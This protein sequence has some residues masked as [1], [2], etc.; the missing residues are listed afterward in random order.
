MSWIGEMWR[1]GGM[2][3]RGERFDR[4]LDEELRL[5]R[6]M[7]ERELSE[8]GVAA[9]EAKHAANRAFGNFTSLRERTREAW[10]WRWLENFVEDCWYGA[11]GLRK[12]PGY[13][14]TTV[15]TLILGI[16][17][18]TAIFSVVNTVLLRPLPYIDP[19]RLVQIEE[20][21]DG[22]TNFSYATY[23]D[24]V[25]A[26]PKSLEEIASYRPW[27]F[28]ISGGAE[29]EQT[30]GAMASMDLFAAL[31]VRPELGRVFTSD[32][33]HE[34]AD[35]VAV[36]SYGL[37]QRQFG[38]STDAIGKTI[39]VS[40]IPTVIVGVMPAGF[41]F[42]RGARIWTPLVA[43]GELQNN[44]RAH[45]FHV[46]GRTPKYVTPAQVE[47]EL[48]GFARGVEEQ[49]R[50]VDPGL[51]ITAGNLRERITA[52]VRPGLLVLLGAVGLV[53]L[54]ACANVANLMLMR[55]TMRAREF[56]VRA[57]LGAGRSRLLRQCFAESTVLGALGAGGGVL[58]AIWCTK[59]IAASGPGDVPRLNEVRA[60]VPTMLFAA[61]LALLTAFVFGAVPAAEA[62]WSDP[63]D[64]LKE[65]A[66]GTASAKGRKLRGVLVVAEIALAL[67]LLAGAGLLMNS[68]VRLSRVSP[69]FDEGNLL[70]ANVFLSPMKFSDEQIAPF[71]EAVLERVRAL[72]GVKSAG[73]VNTLPVQGGAATDFAVEGRPTPRPEEEPNADIR[74]IAGDYFSTMRIPLLR[75]RWFD[76]HDGAASKKVMV[77]NQT[78]AETYWPGVSAIGQRVTMKDW[79]PPLTGEVVG[80]VG[81]V[82]SDALDA[83]PGNMIYWPEAQFPSIFDN[84]VVRTSGDPMLVAADLKA[85]VHSVDADLPV[86]KVATMEQRLTDS[87]GRRRLQAILLSAFAGLALSMATVGIYGVMAYSVSGRGREIG[88]RIALGAERREVRN[89][90]LRE[91]LGWAALGAGIGLAGA[92]GLSG[93]LSSLLYGVTPRDPVTLGGV[94]LLL[95]SVAMIACYLPARRATKVD[96]MAALRHE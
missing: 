52:R 41:D 38:C 16:G 33:F 30:D 34:G 4:E 55:N 61:G 29:P 12:N 37:W 8:G 23:R 26:R 28:N 84:L 81:N 3:L 43:N 87:V 48:Q 20:N 79:G 91:G 17:A 73:V 14:A 2:L 27:T 78:M 1:R 62:S 57:A 15:I 66:K 89:L 42:P 10:G 86:A 74:V 63:N 93:L 46:I 7:K 56:A 85:A 71:F 72:P 76:A 13:A 11:R 45:L 75:G 24:L 50:G 5:H 47:T 22:A 70:T 31:G 90:I 32:E 94:T 9:D 64:T 21:H 95:V 77:I 58:L 19:S 59:L 25:A 51:R 36:L 82:K 35:H 6:E 39:R 40:D 69:G 80:V 18:T 53:L 83:Q 60:D 67:M 65:G 54:V 96:P 68:F 88:I 92:V 49:N 44:R